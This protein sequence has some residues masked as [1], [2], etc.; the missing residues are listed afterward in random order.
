MIVM[1]FGGTSV[2]N[3]ER[4]HPDV[5]EAQLDG[6]LFDVLEHPPR[7]RAGMAPEEGAVLRLLKDS[8]ET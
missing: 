8:E 3:P 5:M 1:K 4:I 6:R 7:R 2:A